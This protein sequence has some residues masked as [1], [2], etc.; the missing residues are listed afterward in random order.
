M[1]N[2]D[3]WK[4]RAEEREAEWIKKSKDTIEKE[5]AEYYRRALSRITD[6]IAVLYG[7][8][9]K[10]NN[11]TYTEA[12]K[13]LTDK[14]FKQWRMSLE[15]YLDAI[16]KNVDNKLLLELNTL[17]MR[18]RISRLDKFIWRYIKKPLQARHGQRKWH[19]KV[20]IRCI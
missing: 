3:Y 10:D 17:A 1:N 14:E 6:D 11:L 12:S 20:F 9:A 19:D 7:R 15:E 16:D 8:Y 2:E 5:L 18:K 4:K 13:L